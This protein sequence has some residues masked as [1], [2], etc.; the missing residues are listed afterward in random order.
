MD[1]DSLKTTDD[2]ANVGFIQHVKLDAGGGEQTSVYIVNSSGT[3]IGTID[4]KIQ[5]QEQSLLVMQEILIELKRLN[6]R[7][8]LI[9]DQ[10]VSGS[11]A[12]QN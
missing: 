5:V 9:F 4:N 8:E 2:G 12:N 6:L 10:E 7:D 11:D 3:E 1:L